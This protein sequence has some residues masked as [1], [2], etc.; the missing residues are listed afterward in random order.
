MP[1]ADSFSPVKSPFLASRSSVLSR[2]AKDSVNM[3]TV[4]VSAAGRDHEVLQE[5]DSTQCAVNP[6]KPLLRLIFTPTMMCDGG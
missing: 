6:I 1:M 2:S 5:V 4:Q 3:P